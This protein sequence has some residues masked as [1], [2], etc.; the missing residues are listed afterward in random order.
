MS[1]NT[2]KSIHFKKPTILK[3][4]YDKKKNSRSSEDAEDIVAETNFEAIGVVNETIKSIKFAKTSY[5]IA[6]GETMAFNPIFIFM[7][8]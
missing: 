5:D 6:A 7:S 8:I 2:I 3:I 4:E 1:I